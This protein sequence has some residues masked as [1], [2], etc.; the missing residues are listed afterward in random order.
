[1]DR[2]RTNHGPWDA[3]D[4]IIAAWKPISAVAA[5]EA[6]ARHSIQVIQIPEP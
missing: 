5:Q 2:I 4:C 6:G 3:Q 1:M